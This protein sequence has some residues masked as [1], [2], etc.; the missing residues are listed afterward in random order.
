MGHP[1]REIGWKLG[2]RQVSAVDGQHKAKQLKH[3]DHKMMRQLF[4]QSTVANALRRHAHVTRRQHPKWST[5]CGLYSK[6]TPLIEPLRRNFKDVR[7]IHSRRAQWC[8]MYSSQD[9]TSDM[10]AEYHLQ[11]IESELS[12]T[13]HSRLPNVIDRMYMGTSG[14]LTCLYLS[15]CL[16]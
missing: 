12:H 4:M 8:L 5:C 7:E 2:S 6:N 10:Q 3:E 14:V 11:S 13:Q 9:G 15:P 1:G 16:R